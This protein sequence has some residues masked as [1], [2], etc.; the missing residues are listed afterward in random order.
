MFQKLVKS[1]N[2][3]LLWLAW[4]GITIRNGLSH[5]GLHM[6]LKQMSTLILWENKADGNLKQCLNSIMYMPGL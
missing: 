3:P 5:M 1:Y 6:P 2:R 4:E